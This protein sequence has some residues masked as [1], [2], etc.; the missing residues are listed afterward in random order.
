MGGKP[1][2]AF[3]TTGPAQVPTAKGDKGAKSAARVRS[4]TCSVPGVQFDAAPLWAQSGRR[5]R[6][7]SPVVGRRHRRGPSDRPPTTFA[8]RTRPATHILRA[9]PPSRPRS[10][11]GPRAPGAPP[12]PL[13]DS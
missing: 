13:R 6:E 3:T 2:E 8:R 4:Q 5:V 9:G 12:E 11:G 10:G 1:D 7:E